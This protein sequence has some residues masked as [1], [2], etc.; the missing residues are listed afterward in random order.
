[1]RFHQFLIVVLVLCIAIVTNAAVFEDACE[2]E[3]AWD[4]LDID[5]DGVCEARL[6][7]TS[8]QV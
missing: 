7:H 4:I 1:M 2:S 6:D 3:K 8:H 5:G